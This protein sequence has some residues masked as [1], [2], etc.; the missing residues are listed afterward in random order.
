MLDER[1]LEACRLLSIGTKVTEISK[2][3]GCSR[4]TVYDWQKNAEFAAML[5]QLGQE[6]I[7]SMIAT[8]REFAPKAMK[9]LIYLAEHAKSDKGKFDALA[10]I[11]DKYMSNATKVEIDIN[12]DSDAISADILDQE[13]SEFDQE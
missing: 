2:E 12:K 11:I 5:D 8:G 6:F 1:Q 3:V 13:L 9:Q 4:Q 10:K 7:S